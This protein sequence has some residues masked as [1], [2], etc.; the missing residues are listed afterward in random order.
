MKRIIGVN[1]FIRNRKDKKAGVIQFLCGIYIFDLVPDTTLTPGQWSVMW[2]KCK[3]L[4]LGKLRRSRGATG[5]FR[6]KIFT[7]RDTPK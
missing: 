4:R 3:D 6:D 7:Q 2:P 5:C 1:N